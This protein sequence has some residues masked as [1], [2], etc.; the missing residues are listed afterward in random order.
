MTCAKLFV[1]T[2]HRNQGLH[3]TFKSKIFSLQQQYYCG[4]SSGQCPTLSFLCEA[5]LEEWKFQLIYYSEIK[6]SVYLITDYTKKAYGE[7]YLQLCPSLTYAVHAPDTVPPG[8]LHRRLDGPNSPL[9]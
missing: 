8:T 5:R 1:W 2:F 6:L 9:V 3:D 4:S 7:V